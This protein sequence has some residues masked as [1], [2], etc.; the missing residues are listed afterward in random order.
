[1]GYYRSSGT[2]TGGAV[3]QDRSHFQGTDHAGHVLA[4]AHEH[5]VSVGAELFAVAVDGLLRPAK[6]V[7]EGE[8]P[9]GRVVVR[10]PPR[11]VARR[12]LAPGTVPHY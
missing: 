2:T 4:P 12:G 11:K 6:V 3:G 5:E 9:S 10:C 8:P 1:M 7:F